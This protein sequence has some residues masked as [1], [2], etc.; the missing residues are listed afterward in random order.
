MTELLTRFRGPL[1]GLPLADLRDL[2]DRE[3]EADDL[4]RDL[5]AAIIDA[6]RNQGDEALRSLA[7][8][9]DGVALTS[10]EVDRKHWTTA[11]DHLAPEVRVAME[12]AARNIEMVHRAQLP[13]RV[14]VT[15]E[16]GLVVDWT[17]DAL[18]RVGVYVPG[19]KATYPSSVLMGVIPARVAGVREVIVCSPPARPDRQPS[20]LVLAACELAGASRVFS[21]GGAGAIAAMAYGTASVPTVDRI[22]GPGNA[23][24]AAAKLLVS[25]RVA[26][27]APAGPSELLILA[28]K[29]ADPAFLAREMVAQAEHDEH[30]AVVAVVI[31]DDIGPLLESLNAQ[32]GATSRHAIVRA[33]LAARGAVLTA[34]TRD[35]AIAFANAYAPEHLLLALT[36]AEAVVPAIRSAGAVFV[37]HFSSV[38]FGDYATGANHTLPTAGSARAYSGL[39]V[40]DFF[41]W[42]T[43]QTLSHEAA[44]ALSSSVATLAAAEGFDGH[45]RAAAAFGHRG[46]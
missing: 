22:V 9:Y 26:I 15:V 42:T 14:R 25:N 34:E 36:D 46:R 41:R 39:S 31:G 32:V 21:L 16:H 8:E 18:G 4:V 44:T 3:A 43:V 5:A 27:D 10:L 37:G 28:D 20:A 6:V 40:L 17:P 35:Q 13:S 33:A 29:T 24:V 23:Y 11:L 2:L 38:V 19:G 7:R 45:A 12:R 30:A 1:A